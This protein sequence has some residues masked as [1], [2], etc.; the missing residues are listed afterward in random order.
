M[1]ADTLNRLCAEHVAG[2]KWRKNLGTAGGY[3]AVSPMS[4]AGQTLYGAPHECFADAPDYVN[5]PAAVLALLEKWDRVEMVRPRPGMAWVVAIGQCK[6]GKKGIDA[7][8]VGEAPTFAEAG[9]RALLK[10]HGCEVGE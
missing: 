9:V 1:T 4:E 8:H 2:W 3:Q 7:L 10:A 5:D 6:D